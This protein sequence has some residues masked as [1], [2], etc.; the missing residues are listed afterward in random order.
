M[1]F[2][3][4]VGIYNLPDMNVDVHEWEVHVHWIRVS[5]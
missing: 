2:V 1:P 4:E 3:M 5:E